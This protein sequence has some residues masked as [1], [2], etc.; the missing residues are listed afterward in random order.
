[1]RRCV[2]AVLG[3][4]VGLAVA[5]S[6]VRTRAVLDAPAVVSEEAGVAPDFFRVI[7]RPTPTVVAPRSV[8]VP[9]PPA[10]A[11]AGRR[12]K[13]VTSEDLTTVVWGPLQVTSKP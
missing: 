5:F 2:W 10:P 3:M 9:R 4:L 1:M 12:G 7:V 6:V 8:A 11:A 13:K